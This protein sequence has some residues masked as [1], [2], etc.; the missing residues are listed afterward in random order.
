MLRYSHVSVLVVVV[1]LKVVTAR[2]EKVGSEGS[3]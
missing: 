3:G 1:M 2:G